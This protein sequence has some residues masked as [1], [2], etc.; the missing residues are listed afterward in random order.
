MKNE[1]NICPV[2]GE[3]SLLEVLD[4]K[5]SFRHGRKEHV[6]DGLAKSECSE[7]GAS[8]FMPE[9]LDKNNEKVKLFQSSLK[10]FIS[11]TKIL[12]LREKYKITQ[13]QA[14]IIFGGGPTA[15]S[16]YERGLASPTAGNARLM[17]AALKNPKFM[18]SLAEVQNIKISFSSASQECTREFL[19]VIPSPMRS[20]IQRYASQVTLPISES[21]VAL[22]S[23]GI[24]VAKQEQQDRPYMESAGQIVYKDIQSPVHRE[25]IVTKT[26]M[27]K[28]V[29]FRIGN[30]P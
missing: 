13:S 9:Q 21:C 28:R 26:K 23:K 30:A 12:E 7:C 15:F 4:Y 18:A 20:F 1:K 14:N 6:V 16:K 25:V 11:A 19:D 5:Y 17:L 3:K 8:M 10:D 22:L 24:D 27:S 29:V 2:C